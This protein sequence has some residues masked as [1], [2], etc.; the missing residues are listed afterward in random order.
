MGR[1]ITARVLRN[2]Y[3]LRRKEA[4][5]KGPLHVKPES[6]DFILPSIPEFFKRR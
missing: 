2:E 4:R 3:R 1:L 5:R 6:V